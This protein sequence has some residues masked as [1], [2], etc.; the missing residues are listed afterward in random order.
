MEIQI[1]NVSFQPT[2]TGKDKWVVATNEGN[3]SVWE[4]KIAEQL[5]KMIGQ[6]VNVEVRQP[7]PNTNY[8]PTI[9]KVD[10]D[11][12]CKAKKG[13]SATMEKPSGEPTRG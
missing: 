3:L 5:N 10:F 6:T 1:G 7:A 4:G 2:K 12:A 13:T 8:I 9:T 11:S